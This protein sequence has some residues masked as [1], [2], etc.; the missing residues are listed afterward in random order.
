MTSYTSSIPQPSDDPSVSQDQILENFQTLN[1]LYGTTGDHYPWTVTSPNE[2]ARHAKVTMPGLPTVGVA[3]GASLPITSIGSGSIFN[4]MRDSQ[5]TP[6]FTRDNIPPTAPLNNIWPLLPIKAYASFAGTGNVTANAVLN[7]SFN[8]NSITHVM[9]DNFYTV[10]ITNEM[11]TPTY[12]VIVMFGGTTG[13]SI[14]TYDG[15]TPKKKFTLSIGAGFTGNATL[16]VLE[17]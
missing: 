6:F 16:I 15:T 2:G 11:R 10:N 9:N 8:I 12:G 4:Q 17:S 13:S 3:P 7:D 5:T 14:Y 1:S